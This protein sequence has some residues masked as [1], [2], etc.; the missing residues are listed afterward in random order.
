MQ[1]PLPK[2]VNKCILFDK[3]SRQFWRGR[4]HSHTN[5]EGSKTRVDHCLHVFIASNFS[6][7]QYLA[8]NYRRGCALPP[9]RT[10][11]HVQVVKYAALLH[12]RAAAYSR[13]QLRTYTLLHCGFKD[14]LTP[15]DSILS[16]Q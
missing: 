16:W 1:P 2:F 11:R 5:V 12:P 6:I 4:N 7:V 13:V 9:S 14:Q 3:L 15:C 10:I 8:T